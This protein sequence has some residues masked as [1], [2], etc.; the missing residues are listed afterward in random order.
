[1]GNV[2]PLVV[3]RLL[4]L[5]AKPGVMGGSVSDEF[6]RRTASDTVSPMPSKTAE[7]LSRTAASIRV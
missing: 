1:M 3:K 7:A 5:G 4:N 6:Q 2:R